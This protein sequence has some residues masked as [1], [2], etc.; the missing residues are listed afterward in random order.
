MFKL[1][2]FF[3]RNIKQFYVIHFWLNIQQTKH[4]AFSQQSSRPDICKLNVMPYV[5]TL[6]LTESASS[7]DK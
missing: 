1:A 7:P 2:L 5:G 4:S 6:R 3:P